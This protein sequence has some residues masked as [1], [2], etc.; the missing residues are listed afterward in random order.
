MADISEELQIIAEGRYG[1]D[2]KNAII[3][4][5]QKLNNEAF[6]SVKE[7]REYMKVVTPL[8]NKFTVCPSGTL[9]ISVNGSYD[10]ADYDMAN[11]NIPDLL[12]PMLVMGQLSGDFVY[13]G[14]TTID[15]LKPYAFY[16]LD[17]LT[18][19]TFPDVAYISSHAFQACGN[20][21]SISF[22][23]CR[24]IYYSAFE[25]CANLQT[26]YLPNCLELGGYAFEGC[27][28]LTEISFP[29]LRSVNPVRTFANCISLTSI[30]LLHSSVITKWG[31]DWSSTFFNTPIVDS[32]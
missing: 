29:R 5:I 9:S 6:N 22:P 23:N 32:A 21:Q 24:T 31:G 11:V 10:V 27:S 16:D 2:V 20:L 8:L 19:V 7:I 26:V 18:G 13:S 25:A 4:A 3:E 28:A 12:F 17:G 15:V 1:D 14:L 30:Y